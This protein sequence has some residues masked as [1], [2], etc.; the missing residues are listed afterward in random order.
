MYVTH[1]GLRARPF[2]SS[3]DPACYYPAGP[4]EDALQTVERALADGEGFALITGEPGIGKSL[5][6]AVLLERTADHY[7]CVYLTNAHLTRR[8]DLFQAILFDLG[9]AYEGKSEQEL[10][11]AV[12]D[13]VMASFA[14]GKATLIVIDD[15]HHLPIDLLEELRLLGNLETRH[16]KAVHVVLFAQPEILETLKRPELKSLA[17]RLTARA[18]LHR[19]GLPDAADYLIHHLRVSGARPET[20]LPDEPLALLARGTGGVPRLA[21][22]AAHIALTL[23]F[24]AG[25]GRVDAEAA[26]EALERL[27]LEVPADDADSLSEPMVA[28]AQESWSPSTFSAPPRLVFAP[29]KSG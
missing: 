8:A 28:V 18:D 9:R 29:G 17:Q 16:G 22:Q 25:N 14:E 6:A 24:Q 2:R 20:I 12:T 26:L 4:H 15:A 10:R 11:L 3:P 21:N 27:G 19:L 23:T 5:T 7:A 13:A 1:F